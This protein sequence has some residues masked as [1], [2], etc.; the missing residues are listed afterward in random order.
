MTSKFIETKMIE[1]K[2]IKHVENGYGPC[3][4]LMSVIPH[5][6]MVS[7]VIGA[8][9]VNSCA[10]FLNKEGVEELIDILRDIHSAMQD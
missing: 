3:G 7:L 8:S 9:Y 10:S 5:G 2:T 4:S 1:T 6:T